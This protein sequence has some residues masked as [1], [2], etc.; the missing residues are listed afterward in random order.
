[1]DNRIINVLTSATFPIEQVKTSLVEVLH[2]NGIS[3]L[4]S[5]KLK[6]FTGGKKQNKNKA[7]TIFFPNLRVYGA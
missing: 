4:T 3:T 6:N 5:Q 1:M 7:S 2:A